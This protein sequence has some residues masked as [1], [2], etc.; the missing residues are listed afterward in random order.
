MATIEFRDPE[1]DA[2]R[3]RHSVLHAK[4]GPTRDMLGM[5]FFLLHSAVCLYI[6]LGWLVPSTTA[7]V[8]YLAFLPLIAM[9][10]QVNRGS[11]VIENLESLARTGRWRDPARGAEGG[12]LSLLT[13]AAFGIRGRPVLL[14]MISYGGLAILWL[15][16]FRHL[17][18]LGE[19]SLLSLF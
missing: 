17:S 3:L 8:F 7:L 10:W 13:L 12:F 5:A 15:L 19:P 9:Q 11:C 16:A 4:A 1:N 6:V 2:S 18:V 14:D